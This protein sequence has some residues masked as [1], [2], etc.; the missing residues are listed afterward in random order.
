MRTLDDLVDKDDPAIV[1]R[2]RTGVNSC[3][4]ANTGPYMNVTRI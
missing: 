3:T 1:A 4:V 2:S